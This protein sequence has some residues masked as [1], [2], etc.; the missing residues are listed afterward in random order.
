MSKV[1]LNYV[2]NAYKTN[3]GLSYYFYCH[4]LSLSLLLLIKI[5]NRMHEYVKKKLI[6]KFILKDMEMYRRIYSYSATECHQTLPTNFRK[7]DRESNACNNSPNAQS[8]HAQPPNPFVIPK[9]IDHL[10]SKYLP[11]QINVNL[12]SNLQPST[13]TLPDVSV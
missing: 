9:S 7:S 8:N 4:H 6:P 13:N 2:L 12:T 5:N 1:F 11:N 10:G 3:I